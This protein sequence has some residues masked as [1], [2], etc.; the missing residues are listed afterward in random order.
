MKKIIFAVFIFGLLLLPAI[1]LAIDIGT[2]ESG[3]LQK[4]AG[5]AGYDANTGATTFA[6]TLGLVV[7]VV[8]SFA[9]IIFLALMVYAG[10]L[11]MTARGEEAKVDKAQNM[12]RS[13]VIGLIIT[14]GAYSITQFIVPKILEST[15]GE[16]SSGGAACVDGAACSN[17]SDCGGETCGSSGCVC[18]E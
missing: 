15:A 5:E 3:Y 9:G 10:Y 2:G 16:G 8:M 18:M 1:V 17:S 4:A 13:A 11:W 6:S 12:I 14:L 7:R